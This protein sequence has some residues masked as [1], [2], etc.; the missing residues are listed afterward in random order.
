[1]LNLNDYKG[2]AIQSFDRSP[3]ASLIGLYC[4]T[5]DI[6]FLIV[7]RKQSCP[8]DYIPFGSVEWCL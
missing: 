1:M 4:F 6:P 2:F 5:K 8:K 7:D 3:E